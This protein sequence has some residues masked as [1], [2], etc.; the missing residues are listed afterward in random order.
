M[1][2]ERWNSKNLNPAKVLITLASLAVVLWPWAVGVFRAVHLKSGIIPESSIYSINAHAFFWNIFHQ[3]SIFDAGR[4]SPWLFQYAF[5]YGCQSTLNAIFPDA[6]AYLILVGVFFGIGQVFTAKFLITFVRQDDKPSTAQFFLAS[7]LSITYITSLSLFNYLQ[8]NVL[9]ALPYLVLPI[10]LYLALKYIRFSDRLALAPFLLFGLVLSD[11]NIFHDIIIVIAVNIIGYIS[12]AWSGL[13]AQVVLRRLLL[14]DLI[15]S[16]GFVWLLTATIGHILYLGPVSEFAK[17]AAEGMYSN[18]ASYLNIILQQTDWGLFD[19]WNGVPYY[20]FAYFY[21][22]IQ[23]WPFGLVP[24]MLVAFS[25]IS[26]PGKKKYWN[27]AIPLSVLSIIIFLFMF[28][29]DNI[30]YRELYQNFIPFQVFRN[31]TKLAPLLELC[32]I[33]ISFV[34]LFSVLKNRVI[35]ITATA[36][37]VLGLIYNAPYWIVGAN[38]FSRRTIDHIPSYWMSAA[39]YIQHHLR[40]YSQILAVPATYIMESY[41]WGGKKVSVQG[42]LLTLLSENESYRLS[43][44]LIGPSTFQSDVS[45]AFEPSNRSIRLLDTNYGTLSNIVQKYHIDYVVFTHDLVSEYQ[46]TNDI[47]AWLKRAGYRRVANF[48]PVSIYHNRANYSVPFSGAS[49]QFKKVNAL[50]FD[51]HLSGLRGKPKVTLRVPFHA[52]WFPKVEPIGSFQCKPVGRE[53]A[54]LG[55]KFARCKSDFWGGSISSE[56]AG[57]FSSSPPGFLHSESPGGNNSWIINVAAIRKLLPRDDYRLRRN[58]SIDLNI[59]FQFRPQA[60]TYIGVLLSALLFLAALCFVLVVI[61]LSR[62]VPLRR[63][64]GIGLSCILVVGLVSARVAALASGPNPRILPPIHSNI[65]P[66]G[67]RIGLFVGSSVSK[68]FSIQSMEDTRASISG[69]RGL[70]G[71][72]ALETSLARTKLGI[73]LKVTALRPGECTLAI[74]DRSMRG[75]VLG[76]SYVHINSYMP[77]SWDRSDAHTSK[78]LTFSSSSAPVRQVAIFGGVGR[79]WLHVNN[80]CDRVASVSVIATPQGRETDVAADLNVTPLDKGSCSVMIAEHRS[81]SSAVVLYIHV[82]GRLH[83]VISGKRFGSLNVRFNSRYSPA[84]TFVIEKAEKAGSQRPLRTLG[85][86]ASS[87]S[88][89]AGIYPGVQ[90]NRGDIARWKVTIVPVHPGRCTAALTDQLDPTE[91]PVYLQIDV[92]PGSESN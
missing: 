47:R 42:D 71:G 83:W 35:A 38:T 29:N 9:F 37:I 54:I 16:P 63:R 49:V 32:L 65:R 25:A 46:H 91:P 45:S 69:C 36:L 48:G 89:T 59:S 20:S 3:R 85:L 52:G 61:L 14:L 4:H 88:T 79:S 17:V 67:R 13:N 1:T 26:S 40:P 81:P 82:L 8:N 72:D 87:C 39:S 10:L 18:N 50:R 64:L 22:I 75:E 55:G 68:P 62:P 31:I 30:V 27:L 73:I 33:S 5:W 11:L 66:S 44:K 28:G 34:L 24:Y 57:L 2:V 15:L 77:L 56:I 12:G 76:R 80:S 21:R 60:I 90:S 92:R 19:S 41:N 43:E 84:K 74:T 70:S 53:E 23:V 58:G 51:A 6:V 86:G 78:T 7:L